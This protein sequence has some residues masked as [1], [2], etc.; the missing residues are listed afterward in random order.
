[1]NW[2]YKLFGFTQVKGI[3]WDLDKEKIKVKFRTYK[4]GTKTILHEG[5]EY[6]T[7]DFEYPTCDRFLGTYAE[8]NTRKNHP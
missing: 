1:M 2:I 5:H 3:I 8:I 7:E 6:K 4:D